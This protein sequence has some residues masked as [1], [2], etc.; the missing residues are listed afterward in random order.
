MIIAESDK[1]QK[2][3]EVLNESKSVTLN[4]FCVVET[5]DGVASPAPSSTLQCDLYKY[6]TKMSSS[7]YVYSY[8]FEFSC[9]FMG[10]S[11]TLI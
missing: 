1:Q 4:A 10:K 6:V 7:P 11:L 5:T 2:E 3:L 8:E 9:L